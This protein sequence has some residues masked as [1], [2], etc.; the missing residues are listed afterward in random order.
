[1]SEAGFTQSLPVSGLSSEARRLWG[2]GDRMP[3]R[4]WQGCPENGGFHRGLVGRDGTDHPERWH[5]GLCREWVE[6]GR[7]KFETRRPLLGA[8]ETWWGGW[9]LIWGRVGGEEEGLG[10]V[11][12][13]LGW[14]RLAG[15]ASVSEV[16]GAG[17]MDGGPLHQDRESEKQACRRTQ[18]VLFWTGGV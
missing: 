18:R 12:A 8:G 16:G 11:T 5:W 4:R 1:M 9:G 15:G 14:G 2:W 6:M 3:L 7:G 17:C 13:W 10:L